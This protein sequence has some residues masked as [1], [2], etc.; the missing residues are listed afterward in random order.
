MAS[1]VEIRE[2][3]A[4]E[5]EQRIDEL[6]EVLA[7][8]V[9]SGASVSFLLPFT[10]EDGREFWRKVVDAVDAGGAILLGAIVDGRLLGT[11]Q[12]RLDTPRNQQHRVEIVKLVVHRNVRGHGIGRALMMAGEESARRRGR[13]LLVLDTLSAS[14]A[15][16]LYESLGF[17]CAGTIPR[18]V[19]VPLGEFGDTSVYYKWLT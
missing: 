18:Y 2:L 16:R 15:A 14:P 1:S 8:A 13:K 10:L 9:E 11:V 7:D 3:S 19:R 6:S 5:A 4:D 17:T 12:V